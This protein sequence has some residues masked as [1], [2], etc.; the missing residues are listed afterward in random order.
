[1]LE[2]KKKIMFSGILKYLC[3][4]SLTQTQNK[5]KKNNNKLYAKINHT[6]KS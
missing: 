4:V 3:L 5:T 2:N 6:A 1:M